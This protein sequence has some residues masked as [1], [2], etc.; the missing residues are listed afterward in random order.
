VLGGYPSGPPQSSLHAWIEAQHSEQVE[1][2]LGIIG[3]KHQGVVTGYRIVLARIANTRHAPGGHG[4]KAYEPKG[5]VLT[6]G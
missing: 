4:L 5:F 6:I 3:F 1:K 2:L